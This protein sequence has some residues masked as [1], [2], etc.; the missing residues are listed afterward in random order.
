M[1][2]QNFFF[3][4][5]RLS[6]TMTDRTAWRGVYIASLKLKTF[7]L[8]LLLLLTATSNHFTYRQKKNWIVK[9][10]FC[11]WNIHI[12]F[13]SYRRQY[14]RNENKARVCP[15]EMWNLIIIDLFSWEQKKRK[16]QFIFCRWSIFFLLF[17]KRVWRCLISLR[18]NADSMLIF[19][20]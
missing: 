10:I 18:V 8:L 12:N 20:R 9:S 19:P 6:M 14:V 13:F 1:I 2:Q 7:F 4:D 5:P 3:C 16:I 15:I 17:E 11:A